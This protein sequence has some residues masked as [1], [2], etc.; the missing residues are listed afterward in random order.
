[1]KLTKR[2]TKNEDNKE[3]HVNNYHTCNNEFHW[4][5]VGK[6]STLSSPAAIADATMYGAAKAL[7]TATSCIINPSRLFRT[8]R[9]A[10]A[11]GPGAGP[12]FALGFPLNIP[13]RNPTPFE[14]SF[15]L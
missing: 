8:S 12:S 13:V 5:P 9:K 11:H 7:G 1:M 6:F 10:V 4:V 3:K 2:I 14:A 15:P